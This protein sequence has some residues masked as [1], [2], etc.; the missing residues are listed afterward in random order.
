MPAP[1]VGQQVAAA[2]EAVMGDKPEDQIHDDYAILHELSRGKGFKGVEGGRNFTQTLE[3]AVHPSVS[4]MAATETL[5]TDF[6]DLF[7]EATFVHKITGGAM[8]ISEYERAV[9]QGA[10]RKFDIEEAKL[11]ALKSA[12]RKSLNEQLCSAGTG[13]SSKDIGGLQ[14]IVASNP[15]TGTVGGIA[16]DTFTWFRNQQASGAQT[17]TAFDNLR[18]TLRS[19]FNLCS[20][21]PAD[22][23]PEYIATTRTVFEGYESLLTLNERITSKGKDDTNLGFKNEWFMFKSARMYYDNDIA[24]GCAY[25]LNHRNLFLCY[26]KGF[27]MKGF[28]GVDPANQLIEVFKTMTVANLVTNNPRRLGVATA[29]T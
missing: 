22:Q 2:W 12:T 10:N 6:A 19:L 4:S 20:N 8:P 16:R 28:P 5:N 24:S 1:N 17:S 27:W 15:A 14:H 18:A 11:N 13:N 29:I 9:N 7:D 26:L 23:H 21:G 3:Y 25:I